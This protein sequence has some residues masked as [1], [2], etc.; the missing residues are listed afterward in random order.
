MQKPL[1]DRLAEAL[2]TTTEALRYIDSPTAGTIALIADNM[3]L[4]AEHN[5]GQYLQRT[6]KAIRQLIE[7][8]DGM[9]TINTFAK[10]TFNEAISLLSVFQSEKEQQR[11]SSDT[12]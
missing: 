5:S 4:I 8:R 6:A 11:A 1:A 2:Q 3:K 9:Y 7:L 12:R 10:D